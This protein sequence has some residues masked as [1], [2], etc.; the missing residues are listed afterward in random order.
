MPYFK[1]MCGKMTNYAKKNVLTLEMFF[2]GTTIADFQ[3]MSR[4]TLR[5]QFN[6]AR[7]MIQIVSMFVLKIFI[8]NSDDPI[9]TERP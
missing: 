7:K 6:F 8:R 4:H 2:L 9:H 1:S 5:Y 3:I